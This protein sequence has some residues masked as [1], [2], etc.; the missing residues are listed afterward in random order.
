MDEQ[1]VRYAEKL[2]A[3]SD[4]DAIRRPDLFWDELNEAA[5]DQA[6]DVD[7]PGAGGGVRDMI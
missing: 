1:M 3:P 6:P 7:V 4:P 2:E 5:E